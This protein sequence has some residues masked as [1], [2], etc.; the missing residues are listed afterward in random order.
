[1]YVDGGTAGDPWSGVS[2]LRCTVLHHRLCY[3]GINMES[4][5]RS[6]GSTADTES[7][8]VVGSPY[9]E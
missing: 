8:G 7:I 4:G 9:V 3:D 6:D 5:H 2:P 1:M